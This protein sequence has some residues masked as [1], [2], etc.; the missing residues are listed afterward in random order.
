MKRFLM[1]GFVAGIA[2]WTLA[3]QVDC[4]VRVEKRPDGALKTNVECKSEN[5]KWLMRN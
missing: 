3:E 2:A 1:L 4:R 5:V